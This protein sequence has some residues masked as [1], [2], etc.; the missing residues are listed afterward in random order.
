MV[1]VV[2]VVWVPA[3]VV[4]V[5]VWVPV[6]VVVAVVWVPVVAAEAA[7]VVVAEVVEQRPLTSWSSALAPS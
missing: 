5:V 3:E 1:V 7:A 6:E 4:V 2:V